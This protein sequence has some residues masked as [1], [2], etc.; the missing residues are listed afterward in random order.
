MGGVHWPTPHTPNQKMFTKAKYAEHLHKKNS[1][2]LGFIPRSRLEEYES[3]GRIVLAHENNDPCGYLIYGSNWPLLNIYQACIDYDVRRKHHGE[4]I[5]KEVED[6]AA[7]KHSGIYL[8]CRENLEAN[9]FWKA[10]GYTIERVEQGGLR[11]N[12]KINVWVK[13]F[14]DPMQLSL[15]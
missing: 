8:R 6:Y 10:L 15:F 3:E 14:L 13:R 11:R 7:D 4:N 5:V 1:E 12:K 2:Y 9:D